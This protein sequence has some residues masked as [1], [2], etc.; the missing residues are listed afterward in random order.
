MAFIHI[1]DFACHNIAL[2]LKMN[3]FFSKVV[4]KISNRLIASPEQVGNLEIAFY[5]SYLKKGMTIF[6]V[7][8]NIGELTL[9]FSRLVQESGVVHSFEA[10][11]SNFHSLFKLCSIVDKKHIIINHCA[12]SNINGSLKLNIYDQ[13]HAAWNSLAD[14]NLQ[15]YG[16]DVK[17]IGQ[18]DVKSL[19][20]DAYCKDKNVNSI[21]L[22]KIDV[23]GAEY[24]VMLGARE[25]FESRAV[26]CCIF[27]HGSTTFDMGNTPDDIKSFLRENGYRIRN[28]VPN[29][30]IFPGGNLAAQAKFSMHIAQ[31][32]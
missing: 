18:E 29:N 19:T 12:V 22:L 4:N 2:K 10:S 31:P 32:K 11:Q 16:I 20:L 15:Q 3:N 28:L 7:G 25:L 14:R 9:L 30:P 21:D 23:E 5:T 8:A 17:T 6:D 1:I 26:K 24:Q 27:E 13:A